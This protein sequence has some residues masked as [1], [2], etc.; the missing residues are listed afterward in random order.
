MKSAVLFMI[1]KRVDTTKR[2]FERIREVQPPRLYIAADGPRKDRP[3]EVQKCADTR[4]V[5]E[6]VD[7]P[8]EVYRLY[9]DDNL[10]CG[11]GVSSAISWFF[12]HEE[13][14]III[15]DDILAHPD[16]FK[17]CDDLLDRYKDDERIQLISGNNYF[18]DG[19]KSDVSYYMSNYMNIWGWASWKRV[20]ITYKYDVNEYD[21]TEIRKNLQN[22]LSKSSARY[23]WNIFQK[24]KKFKVDTW[25]FQLYMN[26]QFYNR[27]S[28][29]PCVNMV[30]NIGMG[31]E[32]AAHTKKQNATV[33]NHKGNSP[34]PL[35]HPSKIAEDRLADSISM[36][37]SKQYMPPYRT[38][39]I[40]KVKRMLGLYKD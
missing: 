39:L 10:G 8:C 21:G 34:Y 29:L 9:R 14:G 24:M 16:F 1:F 17:Y 3:D 28:I 35:V 15:E 7:W 32:D 27:R 6:N 18:Y 26:Q 22:N 12:E 33:S 25:D 4:R 23:F 37:N 31:S 36:I 2:V 30:E 13:Q 19:Y 11:K 38:R 20:W 5:V 40:R